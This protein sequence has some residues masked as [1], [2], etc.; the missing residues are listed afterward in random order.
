[1]RFTVLLLCLVAGLAQAQE[2]PVKTV[3]II[4]PAAPGGNPDVLGRM[5]AARLPDVFGRP[6]VV[7]NVPNAG[8]VVAAGML[9]HPPPDG[10]AVPLVDSGNVAINHPLQPHCAA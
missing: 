5:L 9:A 7:E 10:H 4:A 1:M 2:Y 6:F 3:R 8:G